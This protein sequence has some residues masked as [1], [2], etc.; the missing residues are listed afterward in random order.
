MGKPILRIGA[1]SFFLAHAAFL[2]FFVGILL[3]ALGDNLVSPKITTIIGAVATA[4]A[5]IAVFVSAV[6]KCS[7]CG[8]RVIVTAI[9]SPDRVGEVNMRKTAIMFWRILFKNEPV[10][11]EHCE[12]NR[13]CV[14]QREK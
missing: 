13:S 9:S 4:S 7:F 14:D 3:S 11:C 6:V 12:V 10:S 1:V 8:R 5:V 2:A